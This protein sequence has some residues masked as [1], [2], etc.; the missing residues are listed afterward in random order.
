MISPEDEQEINEMTVALRLSKG[1]ACILLISYND[2]LLRRDVEA[3]LKRQL[4]PEGFNFREF[5]VTEDGYRN[6]PIMLVDMKPQPGDIFLIYDLRKALPEVLEYLNYRREDFVEHNISAI[7]WLDEPTLTEIM[8]KALDFFAFRS[9]PVIEFNVDRAR[10]II[11][12]EESPDELLIYSSSAELESMIALREEILRDYLE[13]RPN[14]LST[15]AGLHNDLGILQHNKSQFDEAIAH[16][17]ESL[18]LCKEINDREL[19]MK[20]LCNIGALLRVQGKLDKALE[21]LSQALDISRMTGN[22]QWKANI[23]HR[24]GMVYSNKGDLNKAMESFSQVL[25]VQQITS[26]MKANALD[27]MGVAYSQKGNIDKALEYHLQAREIY[28]KI[29]YVRGEA[30]NLTN[31]AVTYQNKGDLDKA[32]EYLSQALK[33]HHKLGDN[34]GKASTLNHIGL[35][36]LLKGNLDKSL[37]SHIQALDIAR[38]IGYFK[39][40]ARAL[41]GM[42]LAYRAR[43][44]LNT[45]LEQMIKS[46]K[47]HIFLGKSLS[48][49][50]LYRD[51][52]ETVERIETTGIELSAE[53]RKEI[54]ELVE[55]YE[56]LQGETAVAITNSRTEI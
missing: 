46:I 30:Y 33:M 51:I 16:Y 20:V 35:V 1:R 17:Q 56:K 21:Y 38:E 34:R 13:K 7:F 12:P 41:A 39:G 15:I 49:D 18:R 14:D 3:E 19:E 27:L 53:E 23:L 28:Q 32:L 54:A 8:R 29:G 45:A 50:I 2:E 4:E 37:E 26:L 10:D 47:I 31:T 52:Q 9:L 40:E 11:I 25:S 43:G 36:Y 55:K 6:L 24:M 48:S 42:G 22:T 5:H 44:E